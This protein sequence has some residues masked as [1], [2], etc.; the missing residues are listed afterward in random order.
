MKKLL[1]NMLML[2][3]ATPCLSKE[4]IEINE[5]FLCVVE[6]NENN[7]KNSIEEISVEVRKVNFNKDNTQKP[8]WGS[9]SNTKVKIGG[10]T[11]DATLLSTRNGKVALSYVLQP[12]EKNKTAVAKIYEINL[13]KMRLKKTSL[14]LFDEGNH[15]TSSIDMSCT[16]II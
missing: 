5:K 12:D 9:V 15:S 14:S 2:L 10:V 6:S 11:H 4:I 3:V 7:S 13:A 1:V 16:R 8:A